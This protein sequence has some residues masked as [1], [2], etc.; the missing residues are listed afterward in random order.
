[1]TKKF[2]S[3]LE[4]SLEILQLALIRATQAATDASQMYVEE[5]GKNVASD[6]IESVMQISENNTELIEGIL[7]R[8][9]RGF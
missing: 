6:V 3:E 4:Q 2:S 7:T 1:M 9:K 8:N 5:N